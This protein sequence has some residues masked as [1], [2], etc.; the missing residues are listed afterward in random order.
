MGDFNVDYLDKRSKDYSELNTMMKSLGLKQ[1]ISSPTRHGRTKNSYLDLV[2]TNS[3]CV[4]ASGVIHVNISDHF[5]IFVTRKKERAITRTAKF[6]GRSYVQY[7]KEEFQAN[8]LQ[9][10]WGK[11]Y[12][13]IDPNKAWE[14]MK[15]YIEETIEGMCPQKDMKGKVYDDPAVDHERDY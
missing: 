9:K 14:I 15:L 6:R 13:Q 3:D 7:N 12:R 4:A 10:D 11:F 1:I 5:P 8:L 2:F